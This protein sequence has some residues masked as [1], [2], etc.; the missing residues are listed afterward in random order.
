MSDERE[1]RVSISLQGCLYRRIVNL[2]RIPHYTP[3][4]TFMNISAHVT[5]KYPMNWIHLM[6]VIDIINLT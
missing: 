6:S 5:G 3:H 1:L 2:M 4:L